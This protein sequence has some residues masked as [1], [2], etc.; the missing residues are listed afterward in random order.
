MTLWLMPAPEYFQAFFFS[1]DDMEALAPVVD[2]LRPLRLNGT[3]RSSV[4][5]GNDF[6]VFAGLRHPKNVIP[7]SH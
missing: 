6:K 2:A 4:H 3:I 7:A 1:C 5:I